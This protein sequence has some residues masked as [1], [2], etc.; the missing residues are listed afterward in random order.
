MESLVAVLRAGLNEG[1]AVPRSTLDIRAKGVSIPLGVSTTVLRGPDE[2]TTGVVALFQDLTEVRRQEALSRR[3]DRLAAVGELAAGV[4]HEIRNS[5]LPISGSVQIL[6]QEMKP[7]AEQAKL[8][9]M[10]E[11]ETES[12]ER[13]V[14][15]LLRY[16]RSQELEMAAFDLGALAGELADET[17]V[18]G[19]D[20]LT[21]AV[22]GERAPAWGDAEQVRQAL[23]N[24][25]RNA[26]EAMDGRGTI[27]LRTG[28]DP[29]S[30]P[31]I[32]VLDTGPGIPEADRARIM[33]P[34][35][36]S[37]PGGT[38]LGLALVN[39]IVEDHE[40]RFQILEG[41]GGARFRITLKQPEI[42]P[43]EASRAA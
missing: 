13:F 39:R 29:G 34:F 33:E 40:G 37:K 8:F 42:G 21:V 22:D 14:S 31:W 18:S 17:R 43:G 15:G 36:T 10:V 12:I 7:E 16:S 6:A 3:R 20:A 19:G 41:P 2:E 38:G 35:Y 5:L 1:T 32:E 11:R 28:C 25:V 9:E 23:R 30:G 26:V 4:A 24:L 27:V